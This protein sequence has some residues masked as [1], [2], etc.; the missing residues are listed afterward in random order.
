M[1]QEF[2]LGGNCRKKMQGAPLKAASGTRSVPLQRAGQ[3]SR[4]IEPGSQ[5]CGV[6]IP[7]GWTSVPF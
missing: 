6:L 4:V 7:S 1:A 3:A 2:M 5:S